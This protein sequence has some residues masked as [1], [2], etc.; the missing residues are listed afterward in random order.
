MIIDI[1]G[2]IFSYCIH[3]GFPGGSDGEE[4]ASNAGNLGSISGGASGK[5]L[6]HQCRGHKRREF[7][8]W[9]GKIPWR[10]EWLPLQYSCLENPMDRGEWQ[11]RACSVAE[12]DMTEA[13]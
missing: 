6:T 11:A 12:S 4:F 9:V 1:T 10:R 2:L 7:N 5:E 8:P 3:Q 13:N